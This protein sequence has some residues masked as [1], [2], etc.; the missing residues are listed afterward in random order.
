MT[1]RQFFSVSAVFGTLATVA[2]SATGVDAQVPP[3]TGGVAVINS[4]QTGVHASVDDFAGFPGA[5]TGTA[6]ISGLYGGC[7]TSSG[8]VTPGLMVSVGGSTTG[9]VDTAV[10]DSQSQMTFYYE[11]LGPSYEVE[12]DFSGVVTT[13]AGGTDATATAGI[14]GSYGAPNLAACSST[15]SCPTGESASASASDVAYY[16]PTGVVAYINLVASGGSGENAGGTG[17]Y[18]ALADPMITIDPTFLANNPGT[19]T[20]VFSSNINPNGIPEPSTWAMMLVGFAGLGFAGYRASRKSVAPAA[21]FLVQ[22]S[23]TPL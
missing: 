4:P 1:R 17:V 5:L 7:E 15:A 2:L 20:L 11:V 12:L 22:Q 3:A 19:Y 10:A 21:A 9:G 18:S 23:I 8:S 6:C 13:S 14:G 16:V